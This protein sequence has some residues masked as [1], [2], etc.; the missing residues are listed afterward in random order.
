M[1]TFTYRFLVPFLC[2]MPMLLR[3][4]V[5]IVNWNG[6]VS[7]DWNVA[8]N[9][10]PSGVPTANKEVVIGY[11]SDV[12][13]PI[14]KAGTVAL[15][16]SVQVELGGRLTIES[17]ASLTI[18][19]GRPSPSPSASFLNLGTVENSGVIRID[20]SSSSV[21][22]GI[23]TQDADVSPGKFTNKS[24]GEIYI[25][26]TTSAGLYAFDALFVNEGK[27]FVGSNKAVGTNGLLI[28][29]AVENKNGGEIYLYK[30]S[31][32]GL[33]IDNTSNSTAT[34]TNAGKI[35]IDADNVTNSTGV[36]NDGSMTNQSG[37]E[38]YIDG[39]AR[40]A[41]SHRKGTFTNDGKVVIGANDLSGIRAF[42]NSANAVVN[43]NAR[44]EIYVDRFTSGGIGLENFG[45]FTNAGKVVVG[46]NSSTSG[47]TGI[48]NQSS[49]LNHS[50]GTIAIDR[51]S[52]SGLSNG[53]G[54][55]TNEGSITIGANGLV[56]FYAIINSA[57]FNAN[58]GGEIFLDGSNRSGLSNVSSGNFTNEG[59]IVIGAN[60]NVGT[61]GVQNDATFANKL[62]GELR[63]MRG[64]LRNL[65]SK[66]LTNTGLVYV[67]N[68]L[69]N[70][71]T[72]TNDGVLRYGT[73][74]GVVTN[75]S[76]SSVIVNSHPTTP[77]FSYGGSYN[78]S[79][80]I[81]TDE[82]ATQSAGTFSLPNN[83]NPLAS[84]STG[85]RTLY[86][87]ITNGGCNFI[88]PFSYLVC[89]STLI[90]GSTTDPT[91]CGGNQGSIA[92]TTT[93][94]PDG[95]NYLLSFS[96]TST[97]TSPK[98][99]N[100]GGNSFTLS[101]LTAGT[102]SNFVLSALGCSIPLASSKV[103][104]DP[105]LPTA[106]IV[107]NNSPVCAGVNAT[108]T[109][110]GTSGAT[111]T[112][113]LT[114]LT[115]DQTL[116]LTGA[117]QAITL[118]NPSADVTLTLVSVAKSNCLVG[119]T[120]TS[121]V[122][123]NPLPTATIA[124]GTTVCK[125]V[126][127]PKITLTGAAGTAPYTF[128]YKINNGSEQEITTTN[129]NS[130]NLDAPTSDVG[131]FEYVLVRVKDASS[132]AC[133]QTQMGSAMVTVNPLPTATISGTTT[134]CQNGESP[135]ITFTG[136]VG[137]APYTFTYKINNGSEQEIT[138]TN[139]NSVS[140][141]APTSEAGTFEY[142]L[143]R[144]KDGSST[145]CSQTQ[146]GSTT[147]TV[148]P[149]PTVT[150]TGGTAVCKNVASPKITFTGAAGTAPYTFTYKI[151]NGSEQEITT[152]NGNS[153]SVDAP[154]GEAG[155]FE[156]ILVRVKDASSTACS[157][158][159]SG[160]T[161]VT[162]NPLPTATI[163]GGTVVCKNAVPPKITFTGAVGTAPYTFTYK[164]NNGSEQE[165]TTTNG[166]SVS[167]DAP[168]GEAGTFEYILVRV[169]DASSTTCSQD[170]SGSAMVRVNSLP[171]AT[172][173][174]GTTVCKNAVPPKIT[175]TGAV[176]TAPYTFTYKIN[177]GSEQEITTTNGNS[178]S[179]DAPTSEAGTF[180]Y[181]LVRVKD[182][183]ST[184]C[185]QTQSGSTTVTVNP[186]P[187]AT[188]MGG[189]AVC[190][191]VASPKITFTGAAGTAPYTFT[192]KIN[193][194]SEQ[195]ITTTN[196][197]S[198]SLEAPTGEAGTFE[199]ILVRVKDASSTTCSQ[200]QSGST[201][202]TVNP[203][204]TATVMGGTTVCKNVTS[205]K[206][207]FTGAV[208]TAP[209]TFTYKINN[210]S[211]QEITTT[212]GNSVSL[213]APTGEVG[214]FEYILVRVKDASSTACSQDQS[215]SATVTV[216][217]L[218]TATVTGGTTV[219]KNVTS[220]KVTF[221]GAVGTAPYTFTYKINNGSEQEITTTNGNSI[222]LDAP[223]GEVG[224][225][226]YIL[227]RVK[228]GSS[229]M[230]S[231]SQSGNTTVIVQDKP[232]VALTTLQQ[233]LNEGN[234]QVLCDSDAN[235]VNGL[236][237]TVSGLCVVGNPVWRVQVGSGA[238]SAWSANA[239]VSQP[240]NNQ[241][242]RYQ[243][244]CD[245]SCSVTYTN[246]IE[247][248]INY[249]STVP[250]NVTMRVDGV[251]V[252]VG[253]TKEV[254]SLVNIP[255]VFTANCGSNEV[256]LYSVDGG[257]YSAGAPVGLVDNQYHNY[258]VRC[259]K[260]DGTPSCVESES[261]V[262]RLKLVTIPAA[263]T[264]S[265]SSTASCDAT[266]SFSGQSTCGSLRTIWY[267][268]TTN[269]A[270]PSLPAT[271]SNQTTS[272]Y[273]RCQT[274]TGCVSEK[275]N[276][277]TFT[278]TPTQVA[279]IVT[280]SQEIVCTG[281][282][283]TISA[284]CPAGSTT[285]WSTGVTT[286]SFEVAFSSVTKQTYWAK[287]VF[288]GGCQ[289][290]ESARKD[291]YWNA[292]VV[293][294]INIGESKSAV[295]VNDRSAWGS[296]FITRD[297]GPELDQS[298][299]VNPT[300]YYVEN[301]NKLAP[302][303][304]TVNVDACALG[305]DGS[306]TFDMLATPETG[307]IRS[308]NTHENNAPYFMYANR[309]GWTELYAQNH[310]AYG[311]YQDNGSGGNLYDGGLPKGLYKLGI[312]YWDMKGWGSIYPSTRK[313]QGNVL[314]YQEYWFRIQSKDG[315]GVGAARQ[316]ASVQEA[317]GE[318]QGGFAIVMPNP[319]TNVLRLKV[320]ESKGQEVQTTLMDA[321]GREILHRQ[322]VPETN[323]HQEEFGVSELPTGMYFLKVTTSA[324]RDILK[325][326]KL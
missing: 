6:S 161:T 213:D 90:A 20:P 280:V 150:V 18:D 89:N 262:M 254:C 297:G 302:R 55:F 300:L 121:T 113:T 101:G 235:P 155:T 156:Y 263:P 274:E 77:M 8:E 199:Y 289:S 97:T 276:V 172:I 160:S 50:G 31:S 16:N 73:L 122:T 35:V 80:N 11:T 85:I 226:E 322:F 189:T 75:T 292:F 318:G 79:I 147:V 19:G 28:T 225:F 51:T 316:E 96:T 233:S 86:A 98:S 118:N 200:D 53:N 204:P 248:T 196:G 167:V 131:T 62:C 236:Q 1:K 227:V 27:V 188:V 278:L 7:R 319:V 56:G 142:I 70:Q 143:V 115:G 95:S 320:Q 202:V 182:A 176:G 12:N 209:Y 265:L 228:D 91:S 78:G 326:I 116:V 82:A 247:L 256:T 183:S 324:K 153:V 84:F 309:E 290:A 301:A 23:Y 192:Y 321:S 214:T 245:A 99:V 34:F 36:D 168:T 198:V 314:A 287:C 251:T 111:L 211:E 173:T 222:S 170:Q 65:V 74:S 120:A 216:N 137:T 123:V 60:G 9:W 43:N 284:N 38:I 130:V 315:I 193:N 133:S 179:V 273:A 52:N 124:G 112:Y 218:P 197:N 291:V 171:T 129:G 253:E 45:S 69:D 132:T 139:G 294:L 109:V 215:R 232:T 259:R 220:P 107:N 87:K 106:T 296:Q 102:Y 30:F 44:G 249:R 272:Y 299:Q 206:V 260:S 94:L 181:I 185:S 148:N 208:G 241:P 187:T 26:G 108:F 230:C 178:V 141:D 37:G 40:F 184:A 100:V 258:R 304:W 3:S 270:L 257:E 24:G 119:L 283:V 159:Q 25:D 224:T 105:P 307:V 61:D 4:Q 76:A 165:I 58:A 162:V 234:S 295:K 190:K 138:T 128:T 268:A 64:K 48:S 114:G 92:F 17:G 267:N 32:T 261:G 177:N 217:P 126:T 325:V 149:L 271:V 13:S 157:Q 191:N 286:P 279:P 244:A 59:K 194:G 151:N 323:T 47:A 242:H 186:L 282:T 195:E 66:T 88:V 144:V 308:F 229:T 238:W 311:F 269:V 127:S 152:T 67:V 175:F 134:V 246:P 203:L 54:T 163:A 49:F 310:P 29:N 103:L 158:T 239:P 136:A 68:E 5:V 41:F 243:A 293:S 166:N 83:F 210:G 266:A 57:T 219:C 14:I 72:F 223:T 2:F 93:N 298:T 140:V 207:T 104:A 313:P 201:T 21:S 22:Y 71:G 312:R 255:L 205:P 237:F 250:Q 174:G 39:I 15:A 10:T 146:S 317:K 154:T 277:V 81:Y 46:S 305:T 252:S 169:K 264:V 240:S 212:N 145:A 285:R 164:I 275:S 117:N 125:N 180:E 221:T 231:Q 33:N 63:V 135:K 42:S 303:Y 281:T 306:L 288:E 110:I